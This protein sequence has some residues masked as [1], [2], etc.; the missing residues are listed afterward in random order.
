[1]EAHAVEGAPEGRDKTCVVQEMNDNSPMSIFERPMTKDIKIYYIKKSADEVY[2]IYVTHELGEG[3][4]LDKKIR[5][6]PAFD[7]D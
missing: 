6:R 7:N 3:L 5:L 2:K 4:L 1:M